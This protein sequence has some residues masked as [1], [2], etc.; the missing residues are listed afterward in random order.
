MGENCR[1]ETS[2][3]LVEPQ[4][5]SIWSFNVPLAFFPEQ[6]GYTEGLLM[7]DAD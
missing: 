5:F 4:F 7:L 6:Y 2:N 1:A 3:T